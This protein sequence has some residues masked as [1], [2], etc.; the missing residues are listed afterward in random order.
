M[1]LVD[2]KIKKDIS[3]ILYKQEILPELYI[4]NISVGE[5][6]NYNIKNNRLGL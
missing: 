4:K 2:W 3:Y 5:V 6:F 1:L